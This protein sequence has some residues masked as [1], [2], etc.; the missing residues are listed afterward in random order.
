[1]NRNDYADRRNTKPADRKVTMERKA[2]RLAKR[3]P[4]DF[5]FMTPCTES[6]RN[7]G[8]GSPVTETLRDDA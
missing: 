5:R 8:N 7:K 1:M 6:F 2:V 4:H 3:Y